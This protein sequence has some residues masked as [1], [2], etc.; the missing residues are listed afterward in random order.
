MASSKGVAWYDVKGGGW[1]R[2]IFVLLH[3]PYTLWH[4]SYV[5]IGAALAPKMDWALLGWT[6]LAFFL[7]M[8][9]GGH[10]LDELNGRP[11]RTKIPSKVLWTIA[12]VSILAAL[13]IGFLIGVRETMWVWPCMVFGA[14]IVFA[15]NLEW[16]PEG[17][18][19]PAGFF[20][21][22][23]WFGIAW[24][25]F[26]AIT[27]Y[28][29]QTGTLNIDILLLAFACW[30]YSMAQRKLSLQARFWRRKVGHV[31]GDYA[32]RKPNNGY[33]WGKIT[34]GTIIGPAEVALKLL[35]LAIVAIAAGLLVTHLLKGVL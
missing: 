19:L 29:A 3:P 18:I 1:L 20:H 21:R 26:P 35:N 15:Y 9:I 5:P 32:I 24:G 13:V 28:V 31:A 30:G 11:L 6:V 17:A 16:P 25:A 27:A 8:G 12:G 23:E 14:L 22:D 10:F 33:E 7:A 2:D 4:L 34:I